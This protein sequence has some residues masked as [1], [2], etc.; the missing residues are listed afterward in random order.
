MDASSLA[1]IIVFALCL[2]A[3]L[4]IG[5]LTLRTA[6]GEG[7]KDTAAYYL[8]FEEKEEIKMNTKKI[9]ALFLSAALVAAPVGLAWGAEA[10]KLGGTGPLTGGA[11]IYQR[12][13]E[14][15]PD[16]RRRDQRRRRRREV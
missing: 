5:R 8:S 2:K 1:S 9:F 16:R 14:R 12:G 13:Q 4:Q 7:A 6:A 3:S 10:F 15:R 11:A